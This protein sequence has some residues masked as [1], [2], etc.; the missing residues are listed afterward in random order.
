VLVTH[1]AICHLCHM[2]NN[3]SLH[4]CRRKPSGGREGGRERERD[5][6]GERT[7]GERRFIYRTGQRGGEEDNE[8]IQDGRGAVQVTCHMTDNCHGNPD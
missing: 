8:G 5:G 4:M 2:C 1:T 6:K 3:M 7:Y